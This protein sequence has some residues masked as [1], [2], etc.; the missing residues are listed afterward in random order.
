VKPLFVASFTDEDMAIWLD[1]T[2]R[3]EIRWGMWLNQ[4]SLDGV[5]GELDGE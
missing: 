3:R 4:A 1:R 2:A 5:T